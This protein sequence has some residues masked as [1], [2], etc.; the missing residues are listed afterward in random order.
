VDAQVSVAVV[1]LGGKIDYLREKLSSG[2][3]RITL[4]RTGEGGVTAAA[5]GAKATLDLGK[6]KI[7]G[8]Y[9]ASARA[10]ATATGGQTWVL[11][12]DG[13]A[14][15]FATELKDSLKD[16]LV[17]ATKAT[18]ATGTVGGFL[19]DQVIGGDDFKPPPAQ[20]TYFE[21]GLKI[22]GAAGVSGGGL[23]YA[24]A[25]GA[26]SRAIGGRSSRDGT[27]TL[28]YSLDG[29]ASA[30]GGALLVGGREGAA[31]GKGR[32]ELVL[33]KQKQPVRMVVTGTAE[34]AG[35]K[36]LAASTKSFTE[37]R[38]TLEDQS[39]LGA[40]LKGSDLNTEQVQFRAATELSDPRAR[41]AALDFLAGRGSGPPGSR[42]SRME[43]VRDLLD[44]TGTT[45]DVR[46]YRG[47]RARSGLDASA[48]VGLKLGAAAGYGTS[49]TELTGASYYSP[50]AGWVDWTRCRGGR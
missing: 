40:N 17:E 26:F 46:R 2:K 47:E 43:A 42:D 4:A 33:D 25:T 11:P 36:Q 8:G 15:D 21:G 48:A 7:G 13:A 49:T 16:E 6:T 19:A 34:S 28:Y 30:D 12:N 23:A 18:G 22:E 27:T 37:L 35:G 20:E 14:N 5:P 3:V 24:G 39:K 50:G 9:E 1:N 45:L 41:Q 31:G 10:V 38:K 44:A 29:A 32:I